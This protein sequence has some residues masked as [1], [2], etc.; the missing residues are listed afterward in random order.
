METFNTKYKE[1]KANM[2]ALIN[3]SGIP[4]ACVEDVLTIVQAEVRNALAQEA[5]RATEQ[6]E[7]RGGSGED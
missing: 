3:T 7:E 5:Q 6:E 2:V 1:F 4:L